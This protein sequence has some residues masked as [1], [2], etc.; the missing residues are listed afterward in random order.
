MPVFQQTRRSID[1]VLSPKPDSSASPVIDASMLGRSGFDDEDEDEEDMEDEEEMEEE[2][3]IDDGDEGVEN[4]RRN[5]TSPGNGFLPKG[6]VSEAKFS[7]AVDSELQASAL[8]A[9]KFGR[10]L[11]KNPV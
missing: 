11:E 9:A 3:P 7:S 2:E 4:R 6:C 1:G 8:F 5:S 10:P